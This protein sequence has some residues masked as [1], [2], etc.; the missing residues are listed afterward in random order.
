MHS[1]SDL[2]ARYTT[3]TL[4][5]LNDARER[6]IDELQT[7]GATRL[8]KTLQM[9]ELQRV[10]SSIGMFSLFESML[11]HGLNCSDGFSDAQ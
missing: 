5:A 4:G 9:V 2:I 10:I 3:F 7:S 11:Q 1:F 8:V 6:T